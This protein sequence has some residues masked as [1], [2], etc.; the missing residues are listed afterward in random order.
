MKIPFSFF[1]LHFPPPAFAKDTARGEVG[2]S[3][4]MAFAVIRSWEHQL[5]DGRNQMEQRATR[6][7]RINESQLTSAYEIAG[8]SITW[9]EQDQIVKKLALDFGRAIFNFHGYV[10]GR[11]WFLIDRV[12]FC[13]TRCCKRVKIG[14]RMA[15]ELSWSTH[16]RA[17]RDFTLITMGPSI[18]RHHRRIVRNG[19]DGKRAH[20]FNRLKS[21]C[22]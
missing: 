12:G 1:L 3:G 2:L 6:A 20:A 4:N 8:K 7:R 17:A 18:R 10:D 14:S 21:E 13:T 15:N 16:W 11:T 19:D 9:T 22:L 5:K